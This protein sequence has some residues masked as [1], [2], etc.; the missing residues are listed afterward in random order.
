V[1]L[2]LEKAGWKSEQRVPMSGDVSSAKFVK[3]PIKEMLLVCDDSELKFL[4]AVF[5]E[6]VVAFRAT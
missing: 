2:I 1:F 3:C 6:C 5:S 4:L